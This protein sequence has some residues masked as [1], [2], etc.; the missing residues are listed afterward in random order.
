M[1]V[2][3]PRLQMLQQKMIKYYS[4]NP[5]PSYVQEA[6]WKD[7]PNILR[8]S[9]MEYVHPDARILEIGCGDGRGA[10]WLHAKIGL[11]SYVGCDLSVDRWHSIPHHQNSSFVLASADMLPFQSNYFD[12]IFA[13]FVIEH[14]VF[15]AQFLDEAW[16]ILR[17]EGSIIIVAPDFLNHAMPSER[18]GWRY[19]SGRSKLKHLQLFDA[20][21][22]G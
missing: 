20:L 17:P 10:D 11:I 3:H 5:Y 12:T 7:Q 8:D 4:K 9:F 16:R 21:L 22:T 15:P 1:S 14:L 13:I 2:N 18:I 6:F 19:G